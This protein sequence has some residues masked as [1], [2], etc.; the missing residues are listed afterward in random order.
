MP[1]RAQCRRTQDRRGRDPSCNKGPCAHRAFH[2]VAS[3]TWRNICGMHGFCPTGIPVTEV[4]TVR[5]RHGLRCHREDMHRATSRRRHAPWRSPSS[6]ATGHR[7]RAVEGCG[8]VSEMRN[9][10]GPGSVLLLAG[11]P[12]AGP[13]AVCCFCSQSTAL[14]HGR[15]ECSRSS[16][17]AAA[18]TAGIVLA[19]CEDCS[20]PE[21]GSQKPRP[22]AGENG[23][24]RDEDVPPLTVS[25]TVHRAVV[26]SQRRRS[27]PYAHHRGRLRLR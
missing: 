24:C 20:V 1:S 15:H 12:R 2:L 27:R 4:P 11:L 18:G 25:R 22:C 16:S 3:G 21:A 6:R 10:A 19:A 23:H 17:T 5:V 8:V 7:V 9:R 26:A 14:P 13:S